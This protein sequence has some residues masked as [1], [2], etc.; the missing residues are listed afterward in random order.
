VAADGAGLPTR[1]S[2]TFYQ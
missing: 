1:P 2:T